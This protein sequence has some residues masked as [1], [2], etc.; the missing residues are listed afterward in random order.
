MGVINK[1]LFRGG[2]L[3]KP[4]HRN[5]FLDMEENIHIHYRDLRVELGRSE[6]EEFAKIFKKQ[7]VELLQIMDEK[8][9]EDGKLPNANQDDVRIWTESRLKTPVK[10]HP[11][12][13]SIE[14][15]SDGYHF[16]Y[17]NYKILIDEDDFRALIDVFRTLDPDSPSASTH[18][19][20]LDLLVSNDIDCLRSQHDAEPGKLGLLAA[21]HHTLKIR[22]V[23]ENIGFERPDPKYRRY[24]KGELEILVETSSE[25]PPV[26]YGM[27]SGQPRMGSLVARLLE[28]DPTQDQAELNYLK[29]Q[30]I[31]AYF[32]LKRGTRPGIDTNYQ[33]WMYDRARARVIF[34]SLAQG[35]RPKFTPEE[36][37]RYWAGFLRKN[38]LAFIKPHKRLYSDED[39]Q[40]LQQAFEQQLTELGK[41]TFVHR[42]YL[43]GSGK[44][45]ELGVY[46]VPFMHGYWAKLGSDFDLLIE[47][48]PGRESEITSRWKFHHHSET[49]D[50]D[51]YHIGH[52]PLLEETDYP[53]AFPNIDFYHHLLDA[54]VYLPSRSDETLKDAFL[55][56]FGAKLVWEWRGEDDDQVRHQVVKVDRMLKE[57][58]GLDDFRV[59]AWRV[60][61][62]NAV[63]RVLGKGQDYVLKQFLVAG[64]YHQSQV[65]EHARYEATLIQA[66]IERGVGTA[67][68]VPQANG[69]MVAMLDDAPALLFDWLPGERCK[70]P[71][72]PL[73]RVAEAVAEYHLRQIENPIPLAP[74]F[75]FDQTWDI[76]RDTFKRYQDSDAFPEAL[77]SR[78]K[79]LAPMLDETDKAYQELQATNPLPQLHCHGDLAPKN[80]MIQ[81]DGRAVLFDLNN[82]FY[83][84]RL[85]DLVDTAYEFALAEK[86][87]KLIDFRRFKQIIDRYCALAPLNEAEKRMLPLVVRLFGLLK[88]TKELRGYEEVNGSTMRTA[89]ALAIARF[90]EG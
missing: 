23:L 44:R 62:M 37:Y 20:V 50:C 31:D 69:E 15:C 28:I 32:G 66:L 9:Y 56:R 53:E 87:V 75:L 88:F 45:N 60:S 76:W 65:V 82:A 3:S 35:E 27:W 34:P 41:F 48:V 36:M 24:L 72:Y 8:A 63:Y 85:F 22:N 89:R 5:L 16:H 59:E 74:D 83:G 40:R 18:R 77:S 26:G 13:V 39:Q 90:L 79:T 54:Y 42:V 46:D 67:A 57:D 11:Q 52:L 2:F 80:V 33:N 68:V 12:R 17:R 25:R 10:Y 84:S 14:A 61:T 73:D 47:V 1:L 4:R 38:E 7:S 86:Y 43:M 21:P 81:K 30:V 51:V 55:K 29:C 71:E 78:L 6:F 19:E 49:N 64:N 70:R 58:Y